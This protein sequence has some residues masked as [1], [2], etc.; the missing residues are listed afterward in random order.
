MV[1]KKDVVKV[2]KTVY[3]PELHM[4]V[5]TLGLIY[6]IVIKDKI[7]ITMTF[8]TPLCPYGPMLLEMIRDALKHKLD[9]DTEIEITFEPPWQPSEEL[10]AMFGV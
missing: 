2:L 9:M 6:E 8:T 10:R 3:D 7:Y 4:D 5:W 1:Q